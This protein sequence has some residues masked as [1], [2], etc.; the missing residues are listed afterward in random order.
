M[1]VNVKLNLEYWPSDPYESIPNITVSNAV[2]VEVEWIVAS[3]KKTARSGNKPEGSFIQDG[4]GV[5]K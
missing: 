4:R 1:N 3:E 2:K 5:S